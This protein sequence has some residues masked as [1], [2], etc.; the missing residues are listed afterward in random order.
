[1]G[2]FVPDSE[3][4]DGGGGLLREEDVATGAPPS[5]RSA[6]RG[7]SAFSPV[8][9]SRESLSKNA[10]CRTSRGTAAEFSAKRFVKFR[11]CNWDYM[12]NG[13]EGEEY[14]FFASA[15]ERNKVMWVFRSSVG[16]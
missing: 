12:T 16:L 3:A 9:G 14:F 1:M 15:V 8:S 7:P 5:G 10:S 6:L 2:R 11:G 13:V 4:R